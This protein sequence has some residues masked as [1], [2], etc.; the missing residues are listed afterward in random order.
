MS[1][2]NRESTNSLK[3]STK[4]ATI[5]SIH[6][7]TTRTYLSRGICKKNDWCWDYDRPVSGIWKNVCPFWPNWVPKAQEMWIPIKLKFFKK[8]LS[9]I[10]NFVVQTG[11]YISDKIPPNASSYDGYLLTLS[12]LSIQH[13]TASSTNIPKDAQGM[14]YPNCP[15]K[16]FR[17][18]VPYE[19]LVRQQYCLLPRD[20]T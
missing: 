10:P 11:N 15:S 13:K 5:Q 2:A 16:I 19:A 6:R 18:D 8:T 12:L 7:S 14:A 9:N 17:G 4:T 1:W 3:S 20:V